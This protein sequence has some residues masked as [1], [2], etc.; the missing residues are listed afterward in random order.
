[1]SFVGTE[2]D[3]DGDFVFSRRKVAREVVWYF[4][5]FVHAIDPRVLIDGA[6]LNFEDAGLDR[7][8]ASREDGSRSFEM[9]LVRGERVG[10][11]N[12]FRC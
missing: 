7:L 4:A 5:G 10:R 6:L 8:P 1:M 3:Q 11:A 9:L 2:G 12:F